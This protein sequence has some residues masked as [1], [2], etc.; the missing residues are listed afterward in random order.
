MTIAMSSRSS[1][2]GF[3]VDRRDAGGSIGAI[4][5]KNAW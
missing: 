5:E 4:L 1:T 3:V 2:R